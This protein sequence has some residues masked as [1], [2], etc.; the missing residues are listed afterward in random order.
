MFLLLTLPVDTFLAGIYSLSGKSSADDEVF[1][2][3]VMRDLEKRRITF[4]L[5][6][7]VAAKEKRTASSSVCLRMIR[8]FTAYSR[9][10]SEFEFKSIL[11]FGYVLTSFLLAFCTGK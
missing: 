10:L 5:E 3:S 8:F 11:S 7:I 6:S 2:V 1:S 4:G 9:W